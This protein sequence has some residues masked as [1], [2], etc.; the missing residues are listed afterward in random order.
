MIF[1]SIVFS[2][3]QF[4]LRGLPHLTQYAPQPVE[5]R[6]LLPDPENEPDFY[7]ITQLFPLPDDQTNQLEEARAELAKRGIYLAN[8]T[9]TSTLTTPR[10]STASVLAQMP[11]RAMNLDSLLSLRELPSN[12]MSSVGSAR[13]SVAARMQE[14][15]SNLNRISNTN[16]PLYYGLT[17]F[18]NRLSRAGLNSATLRQSHL[19]SNVFDPISQNYQN[20]L[21]NLEYERLRSS[22]GLRQFLSDQQSR[23]RISTYMQYLN[24]QRGD[25][26]NITNNPFNEHIQE[27]SHSD[28]RKMIDHLSSL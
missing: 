2:F 25:D 27:T 1:F 13:L 15:S 9:S 18:D 24:A 16:L 14:M 3:K 10:I 5:R 17:G 23:D 11:S 4:L 20:N 7:E 26:S 19:S 12:A 8:D 6:K 22:L 21:A 28:L